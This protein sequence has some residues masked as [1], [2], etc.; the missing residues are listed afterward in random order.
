MNKVVI[1][2][3]CFFLVLALLFNFA[4]DYDYT[5]TGD[6][7]EVDF[8]T[9]TKI[10]ANRIQSS[11]YTVFNSASNV[12]SFLSDT[13][14]KIF[15]VF[16]GEIT[17]DDVGGDAQ[18]LS[19]INERIDYAETYIKSL[20]WW[21][22]YFVAPNK[23]S[24]A[25][26]LVYGDTVIQKDTKSPYDYYYVFDGISYYVDEEITDFCKYLGWSDKDIERIH[27]FCVKNKRTHTY[28]GKLYDYR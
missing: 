27:E 20:K 25:K 15:I 2:L 6:S 12:V 28:N 1:G 23:L 3:I 9:P 8:I 11:F 10:N 18:F 13:F 17:L 22:R 14:N 4:D 21:D 19:F 24:T 26:A 7:Y 16:T 5:Y